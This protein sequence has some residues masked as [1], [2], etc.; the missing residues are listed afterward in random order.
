MP[1]KPKYMIVGAVAAIAS[2]A[3]AQS[4]NFI[5][6]A[7]QGVAE[8]PNTT[9]AEYQF[10]ISREKE[11]KP[12]G[13]FQ[14]DFGQKTPE[15]RARLV[16]ENFNVFQAEPNSAYWNGVGI[17]TTKENGKEVRVEG[18]AEVKVRM[19]PNKEGNPKGVINVFFRG[20]G[21]K[22]PFRWEGRIVRG[23]FKFEKR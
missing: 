1:I 11:Q 10:R 9:R 7:G 23:E 16:M 13:R 15:R 22:E 4:V 8:G 18:E 21:W 6:A 20:R 17:W 19:N 12:K 5:A 2:V 14:F 3:V